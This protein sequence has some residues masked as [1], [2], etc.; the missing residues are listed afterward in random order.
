MLIFASS[1][2][3]TITN[4]SELQQPGFTSPAFPGTATVLALEEIYYGYSK[5]EEQNT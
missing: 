5:K 4:H 1:R 2:T 3:L